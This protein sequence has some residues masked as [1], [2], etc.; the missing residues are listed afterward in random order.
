MDESVK[1][2]AYKHIKAWGIMMGS[3]PYY[4]EAEQARAA[5]QGAPLD[6]TYQEHSWDDTGRWHTFSEV[7]SSETRSRIEAILKRMT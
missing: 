5:A 6:A 4:I 7:A 2:E 3:F 1:P